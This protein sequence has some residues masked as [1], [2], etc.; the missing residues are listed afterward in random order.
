MHPT[1][2]QSVLHRTY[3]RNSVSILTYFYSGFTFFYALLYWFLLCELGR[4]GGAKSSAALKLHLPVLPSWCYCPYPLV[5]S[6]ESAGLLKYIFPLNLRVTGNSTLCLPGSGYSEHT[7]VE[8]QN[9][10]V[11][12]CRHWILTGCSWL[13]ERGAEVKKN[14]RVV[15]KEQWLWTY[16]I[17]VMRGKNKNKIKLKLHGGGANWQ[18][19]NQ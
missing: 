19:C 17:F 18:G 12:G 4:K 11:S 14:I 10:P 15:K 6:E 2:W 13:K 16:Y 8:G 5:L 9:S 7:R 1:G 3:I